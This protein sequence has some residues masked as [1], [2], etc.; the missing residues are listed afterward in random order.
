MSTTT[1]TA[2]SN[3]FD[4]TQE[5]L[6]LREVAA[7][8]ARERYAPHAQA[9]DR[10]RAALPLEERRRLAELG[11]IGITLPEEHGGG[12]RPLL[13]ALIVLEELAK[14]S[15]VAGWPVFEG[16]TG[17]ARVVH[18]FGTDEQ[19]ARILPAVASGD[20]TIAV[21]ISEP[22]AGSA[23][24]DASL[25]ARV[26]GDSVVLNGAKRWCSGAGHS[27]YYLVYARMDERPGAGGIGA[28]LV[29]KDK[30]GLTFGPQ[31]N[32]MGFRGVASAD[33]FFDDVRVPV[34]NVV[35]EAGGFKRLFTAFSIERL[36]NATNSLAI[37]QAAL[38][39]VAA[40][41]QERRQF[42]KPLVEFQMVQSALADMVIQVDAARLL[43]YRAAQHAGR[44]APVPL[45][46]SIAKCFANEMAKR[47]S[48]AAIQLLG[49]YGYSSEYDV[50]R[51][52]RDAHGWALAGGT[53]NLQRI[54]IASEYL[55]RRF[56][57]RA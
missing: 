14:A 8:V 19:R 42:G 50:E 17:P 35:V 12:D 44:G 54:R 5:Q 29:P 7:R 6:D 18:L 30:P 39:K 52:H 11:F 43:V 15:I 20:I 34:E 48:D 21:A 51:M 13:D 38:D 25:R 36:G 47:V 28:V 57:Q 55:G 2:D 40:Y 10:D 22:D 23:A 53:T 1:H 49:G 33:M 9:W 16:A 46:A 24:T 31:E 37:G 45:E 32:L 27:E 4:L 26:D 56:D 3:G 41:V